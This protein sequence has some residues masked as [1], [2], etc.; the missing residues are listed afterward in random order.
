MANPTDDQIDR[1]IQAVNEIADLIPTSAESSA[2][3][4]AAPS[5]VGGLPLDQFVDANIGQ[6]LGAT[7][8]KDPQRIVALLTGAFAKQPGNGMGDYQWRQRGSVPLDGSDGGQVAGEQATIFQELKD[9]EEAANRLLDMVVPVVLGPDEDEIDDLKD[10]IRS[11][12]SDIITESGRPGGAGLDQIDVLLDTLDANLRELRAKLG[13]DETNPDLLKEL[14]FATAEQIRAN[15]QSLETTYIGFDTLNTVRDRLATANDSPGTRLSRLVR[16]VEAI[17]NTVQQAYTVMNSVR[18]GAA[19]RRVTGIESDSDTTT[20][21]QLFN[22]IEQS[23]STSWPTSLIGRGAKR[24]EFVAIRLAAQ[25]QS[26]KLDQLTRDQNARLKELIDVGVTRVSTVINELRRELNVVKDLTV[27]IA[28]LPVVQSISPANGIPGQTVTITGSNLARVKTVVFDRVKG[29]N[30]V[31]TD[32]S[33]TVTAPA[34]SGVVNVRVEGDDGSDTVT[35]GFKY[36]ETAPS[37]TPTFV[38]LVPDSG[39]AGQ[40]VAILG[41][42]LSKIT[43]VIFGT[44]FEPGGTTNLKKDPGGDFIYFETP[45]GEAGSTVELFVTDES[46]QHPTNLQFTYYD[47]LSGT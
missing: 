27:E 2:E 45:G 17:P 8:N 18:F 19:E 15:F 30:V 44:G 11:N 6:I 12:V 41:S 39:R 24:N 22:W 16:A 29:T 35:A 40:T 34:G 21:E 20:F 4:S 10:N 46:G 31:A 7:P 28:N 38:L 13:L 5:A 47:E 36:D 3:L 33:V 9:R 1:L 32:A 26:D 23:A 14:D 42:N 37:T 43:A 25:K